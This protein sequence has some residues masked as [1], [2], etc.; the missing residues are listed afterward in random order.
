MDELT[1]VDEGPAGV[2]D[3]P[4]GVEL[5]GL[6]AELLAEL[7]TVEVV[8][9]NEE[10]SGGTVDEVDEGTDEVVEVVQ[11]GFQQ[12]FGKR[13]MSIAMSSKTLKSKSALLE[14]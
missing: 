11:V 10:D 3:G 8:E 1:G 5:A 9:D 13:S 4:A 2:E 12:K 14:T 7:L 6:L